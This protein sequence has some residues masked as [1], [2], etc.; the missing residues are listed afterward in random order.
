MAK[1][2]DIQLLAFQ[3]KPL[4]TYFSIVGLVVLLTVNKSNLSKSQVHETELG[5]RVGLNFLLKSRF[6]TI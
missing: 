5:N 3:F 6:M 1:A 4:S 2:I